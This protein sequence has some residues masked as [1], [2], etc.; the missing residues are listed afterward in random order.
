MTY[1][2]DLADM[3]ESPVPRVARRLMARGAVLAY[4]DPYAPAWSVDGRP[5]RRAN[6][7]EHEVRA[8]DLV[9]KLQ[10]HT[11]YNLDQIS[12]S[13]CRILDARGCMAGLHIERL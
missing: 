11:V 2:R 7:L 1:K 13:A 10:D 6:D 9:I 8:A 4:H 12:R 5:V 3:R